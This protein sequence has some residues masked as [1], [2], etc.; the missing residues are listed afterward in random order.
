MSL[1]ARDQGA[2]TRFIQPQRTGI[3]EVLFEP[4]RYVSFSDADRRY[5]III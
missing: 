5:L 3:T 1:S 4:V 2:S